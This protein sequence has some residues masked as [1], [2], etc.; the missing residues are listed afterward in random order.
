MKSNVR[1]WGNSLAIR[2]PKSLADELQLVN[3]SAVD[4]TIS[5]GQLV[6]RPKRR[7]ELHHLLDQITASNR[8]N[9]TDLGEVAAESW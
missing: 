4:L 7:Q 3:S 9:E 8:H 1:K 6:I 2:L 5:A